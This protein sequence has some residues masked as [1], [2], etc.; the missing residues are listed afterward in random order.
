MHK[1][2]IHQSDFKEIIEGDYLYVDKTRLIHHLIESGEYYFL[3]RPRHFGK[4]LLIYH[5][6]V[7]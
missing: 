1:Y 7:I 6:G 4:S 5:P 3:G 2:P